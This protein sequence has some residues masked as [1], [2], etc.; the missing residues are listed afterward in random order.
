MSQLGSQSF[1]EMKSK[2]PVENDFRINQYVKCISQ[3]I[4]E[5]AKGSTQVN[6][7]ETVVFKDN[8]ANAFALPGGKIGVHTGLLKVAMSAD[9][10][11]AVLGHEVGHVIA[12]HSAERVSQAM[13]AQG[14][15]MLA[16]V[17]IG[18]DANESTQKNILSA[19]GLGMQFGIL[20]PFGRKQESESDEIGLYLMAQSG[21]N[22][23]ASITL[24]Q[25]MAKANKSQPP[26]FLS[27]HPSHE[28]RISDLKSH[29]NKAQSYY[30]K[31]LA[32]GRNPVCNL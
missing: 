27:T 22:P 20:M 11:A 31:A 30:K 24:W 29:M 3:A 15:V 1:N 19:L 2:I 16:S 23:E 21:F 14:G 5:E 7:W 4:A 18:P 32:S 26:E 13:A 17:F 9:Q 10:L 12:R 8:S 25:N 28:T 6:T